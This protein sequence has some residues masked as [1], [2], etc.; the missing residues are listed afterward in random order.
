M[1]GERIAE[2]FDRGSKGPLL[3]TAGPEDIEAIIAI[4]A[5]P[6]LADFILR[7]EPERHRAGLADPDRRYLVMDGA[8]GLAAYII[9]A[10]LT[11]PNRSVELVRIVIAEP[12]GGLGTQALVQLIDL[13][14]G[15]MGAHRL[16]LDVFTDNVRAR[17][18][19]AKLGFREE[20]VLRE[21]VLRDGR[22]RSLVVMAL[23]EHERPKG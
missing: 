16:W 3:R 9:L 18:V 1:D 2:D 11:S 22:W 17:H 5:R 15:P 23:L 21:A 4:E 20:G 6:E 7:W 14:F 13:V 12:G 19:Y 8:E 10:G